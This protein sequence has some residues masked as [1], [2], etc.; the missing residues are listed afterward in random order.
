[1]K[2]KSFLE[3]LEEEY[4]VK[5]VEGEEPS[6]IAEYQSGYADYVGQY[7]EDLQEKD[8]EERE[9]ALKV[10]KEANEQANKELKKALIRHGE[11]IQQLME[12]AKNSP[13]AHVELNKKFDDAIEKAKK[14][15]SNAAAGEFPL[16][17]ITRAEIATLKATV[18]DGSV[19]NNTD[20]LRIQ[21]IGQLAFRLLTLYDFFPKFPVGINQ[22]GTVRY[23]DWDDATK[24]RNA[25]QV[26]EGGT[27]PAS[28][29]AW[30]EF[31][32]VLRKTGDSI[33]VSEESIIDRA[34]FVA[35]LD[36]FLGT[37]V[38]LVVDQGL[39]NGDGTGINLKG[40]STSA[41][42]FVPVASGIADANIF[43][44][45]RKVRT[46]ISKG[47]RSKYAPNFAFMNA[48]DID[49]MLLKKDGENNYVRPDFFQM[50]DGT[51][52]FIVSGVLIIETNVV[53]ENTMLVGDSR[54]ARI[55]E[56]EGGLEIIMG[57]S[58]D[59]FEKDLRTLKARRR[60]LMLVRDVDADAFSKVTSIS[61]ALV[62]LAS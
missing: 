17:K 61:A 27:F 59:D 43:D 41:P 26:A 49:E 54:Y 16:F 28:T 55:Y 25:A 57:M 32:E 60:L 11:A 1:M 42:A 35:E 29:A 46:S 7:I 38:D 22:N 50:T 21:E 47:K 48:D 36:S 34:R 56:Q 8:N 52:V 15:K 37:N 40:V 30:E 39:Y 9:A 18:V 20:A 3:W 6:K 58:A 13:K 44:L 31:S 24:V 10:Q 12:A 5:T 45:I 2:R 4:K 62:T 14:I 51:N 19:A 23:T 53:T 33:K